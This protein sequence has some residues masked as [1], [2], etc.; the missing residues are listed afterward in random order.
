MIEIVN[1]IKLGDVVV[2]SPYQSDQ[3]DILGKVSKICEIPSL[4]AK[5]IFVGVKFVRQLFLFKSIKGA[6]FDYRFSY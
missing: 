4:R 6:Y 3:D 2:A 5:Q 1:E